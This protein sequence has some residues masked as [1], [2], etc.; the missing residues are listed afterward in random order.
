MI[1]DILCNLERHAGKLDAGADAIV[2]EAGDVMRCDYHG[3]DRAFDRM[4][5]RAKAPRAASR[6]VRPV[7]DIGQ[8]GAGKTARGRLA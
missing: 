7:I 5:R 8:A 4:L 6:I 2:R 1:P 3:L